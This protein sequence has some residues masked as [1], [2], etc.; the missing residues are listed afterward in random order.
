MI[1]GIA[2]YALDLDQHWSFS[3][4]SLP[5]QVSV[6]SSAMTSLLPE[7]LVVNSSSAIGYSS[8]NNNTIFTNSS[9]PSTPS[10]TALSSSSSL[11]KTSSV[12]SGIKCIGLYFSAHWCGP[13]RQF[14]P[15]LQQLYQH[16]RIQQQ[17]QQHKLFEIIFCSADDSK[18]EY[19]NYYASMPW[20]AID[21]DDMKREEL[22]DRYRVSGIP[23]LCI[24]AV[25]DGRTIVDNAVGMSLSITLID[26]WIRQSEK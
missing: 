3:P 15:Q 20:A 11:I 9:I 17:Q 24:I 13:C 19:L 1:W 4:S 6:L 14:T 21:Y 26:D 18:E 8:Y 5:Y 10:S 22:M 23:R 25:S 12:L 7:H 16:Y 2:L